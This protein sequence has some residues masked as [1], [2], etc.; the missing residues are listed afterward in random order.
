MTASDFYSFVL[1]DD[2]NLLAVRADLN[3]LRRNDD[4]VA[5]VESVNADIDK[6]PGPEPQFRVLEFRLKL[7][8]PCRAIDRVVDKGERALLRPTLIRL[9]FRVHIQLARSPCGA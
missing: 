5:L 8:C 2:K 3:R 4:R 9:K 1:F 6:L 7:N